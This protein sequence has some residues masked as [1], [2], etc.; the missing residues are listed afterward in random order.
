MYSTGHLD[1][2]DKKHTLIIL[3]SNYL[4]IYTYLIISGMKAWAGTHHCKKKHP[5]GHNMQDKMNQY[6]NMFIHP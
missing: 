3:Y 4:Y 1:L 6:T 5:T 2:D